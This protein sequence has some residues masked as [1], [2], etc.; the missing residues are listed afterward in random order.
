MD[1]VYATAQGRRMIE[2]DAASAALGMRVV[3]AQP[4]RAIVRMTV[5]ADML[6]GFAVAHGGLVFALADTALALACNETDAVTLVAGADIAFLSPARE[7]DELEAVAERRTI[8]GRSGLYDVRV[9]AAGRVVAELRG[10][11]RTTGMPRP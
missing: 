4:G 1:D 3:R 11:T 6:N 8:E 10:R 7:G 9:S 2:A 5:R